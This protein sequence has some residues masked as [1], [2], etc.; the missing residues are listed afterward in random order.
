MLEYITSNI[1]SVVF[2]LVITVLI[3]L[4]VMIIMGINLISLKKRY[5]DFT[6][7][8]GECNIEDVLI[9]NQKM[10]NT[11]KE[12]VKNHE[13][14]I[15]DI[16]TNLKS[17]FEKVAMIKYDAFDD[18]GGQLSAVIVLLNKNHDG[19]LLNAIHTRE[20]SHIYTKAIVKGKTEQALSK[21]EESAIKKAKM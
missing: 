13:G 17:T 12:E 20:G 19:F 3:L 5:S 15:G 9:S 7:I 8:S 21:E 2:I 18:M 6:K 1:D 11:L 4:V 14:N 16:Y 10:I